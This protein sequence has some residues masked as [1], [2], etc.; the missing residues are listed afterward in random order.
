MR[1]TPTCTISSGGA[2][3][4]IGAN[5]S[6]GGHSTFTTFNFNQTTTEKLFGTWSGAAGIDTD[7]VVVFA[8][9]VTDYFDASAEL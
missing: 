8:N 1:A 9:T 4:P 6:V 5:S 3:F 2:W 7:A